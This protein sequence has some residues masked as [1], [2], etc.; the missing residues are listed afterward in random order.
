MADKTPPK[1][2]PLPDDGIYRAILVV[3]VISLVIGAAMSL[4]GELVWHNEAISQT[5]GWIAVISGVIYFVF[6]WLGRREAKRQAERQ[7][8]RP[9]ND[10]EG[11]G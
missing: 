10:G 1:T 3:L 6:R 8:S 4:A 9:G 5:G 7:A 2:P 11:D